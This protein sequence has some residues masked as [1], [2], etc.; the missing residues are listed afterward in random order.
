MTGESHREAACDLETKLS[1]Q[2]QRYFASGLGCAIAAIWAT[3][4]FG[5]ALASLAVAAASYAAVSLA[6]RRGIVQP[7]RERRLEHR[8]EPS[9]RTTPSA[10]RRPPP[11]RDEPC[12][13]AGFGSSGYA[14]RVVARFPMSAGATARSS[15]VHL[16]PRRLVAS[17][18]ARLSAS[19][20]DRR[21]P[22]M[23]FNRSSM[24]CRTRSPKRFLSPHV[25]TTSPR[26][27]AL[28]L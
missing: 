17:R 25:T 9:R 11:A 15:S 16:W 1:E 6:Q 24:I 12:A 26:D 14:L 3:A 8:R 20:P 4:G 22:S 21:W 7:S 13:S 23:S 18:I 10:Q 19:R 2:L 5:A 28:P 27:M